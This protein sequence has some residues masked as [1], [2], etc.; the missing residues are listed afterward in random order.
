MCDRRRAAPALGTFERYLTLWVALCI[1]AGIVLGRLVPAPFQALGRMTV[2]EV[3]IPVAVLI[4]LMIVPM[5]LKVD[6]G[7][8]HRVAEQWRGIAVTVGINWLVKPFSMALLGWLFIGWLFRPWL[9][10]GQ[11]DSYIAGL[12]LLAAAPC[13]AMVFVWSNLTD[14]E[15][16]FTLTPGRAQRHDHGVRLRA[17]R[18][19]AARPVVDHGAVGRRC[20]CRSCST[21]SC[22]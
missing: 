22:R 18:R 19:A 2:A 5:L 11:I 16:N 3:N 21:S 13:T 4:W 17:D 14:G 7:A 15:P 20:S 12:I 8:L 10:A 9:P 1:I 6:F